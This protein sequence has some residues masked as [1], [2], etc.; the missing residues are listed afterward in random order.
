MTVFYILVIVINIFFHP[1][2]AM[3]NPSINTLVLTE[4]QNE[5]LSSIN[6]FIDMPHRVSF[7]KI[8]DYKKSTK[9]LFNE[10]TYPY[11][12]QCLLKKLNI[13]KLSKSI[14][15][16]SVPKKNIF[17]KQECINQINWLA[18][19]TNKL[20][21]KESSLLNDFT[22][23]I[24]LCQP[25]CIKQLQSDNDF[26]IKTQKSLFFLQDFN[27]HFK[28]IP[29]I[30]TLKSIQIQSFLIKNF[31][32]PPDVV[33]M[34]YPEKETIKTLNNIEKTID[35][36]YPYSYH[37]KIGLI[38]IFNQAYENYERVQSSIFSMKDIYS[39]SLVIVQSTAQNTSIYSVALSILLSAEKDKTLLLFDDLY[40]QFTMIQRKTHNN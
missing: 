17:N 21:K 25:E 37:E 36:L 26:I 13:I 34:Q 6:L 33:L 1:L 8:K 23:Q 28:L 27:P 20:I 40:K 32:N 14:L 4:K 39:N 24:A 19:K 3:N 22:Q 10:E 5:L 38:D 2:T 7:Q 29:L 11:H 30:N 31:I 35:A 16:I 15:I 12:S 9:D 18:L